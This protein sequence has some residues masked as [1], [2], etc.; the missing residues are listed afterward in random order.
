MVDRIR[1]LLALRQLTPTQ[2]A[3]LIQVGRPIV[4]HIL[5]GRNKASLEVVQ[6][7]V[8]AFPEVALPWLLSGTGPMLTT[9]TIEQPSSAPAALPAT[10]QAKPASAGAAAAET[11]PTPPAESR[12][13]RKPAPPTTPIIQAAEPTRQPARKFVQQTVPSG[14]GSAAFEQ[15]RPGST[16]VAPV[17]DPVTA[18]AVAAPAEPNSAATPAAVPVAPPT[19]LAAPAVATG[20]GNGNN[21][22]AV[23]RAFG[24]TNKPIRRIVLFYQDGSFADF[25][26]ES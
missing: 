23:A 6:R 10:G 12:P 9:P 22:E 5:S 16:P 14:A 19:T 18:A 3:D 2:F 21:S 24:V 8:A 1:A 26:P 7:I 20:A 25:H 17:T 4:S 13:G 11:P 15:I